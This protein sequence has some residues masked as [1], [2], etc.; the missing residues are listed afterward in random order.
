MDAQIHGQTI[1][2]TGAAGFVGSHLVDTLVDTNEVIALDHFNTNSAEVIAD[3]ATVVKG[4]IRDRKLIDRV[5]NGTDIIFHQ[6]AMRG[7]SE[8]IKEPLKTHDVNVDATLHLLESA[9]KHDARIILASS[10]AIYGNP[11]KYPITESSPTKPISPYGTQKLTIDNYAC[12]FN[13]L[14]GLE[15]VVL[16]YFNV[17]GR[18]KASGSYRSAIGAFIQQAE[19]GGPI[20]VEGDGTQT[21]DF[22][23]V[24]DVVRA[25]LLA[26]TT[27]YTGE[28]YN[29]ATGSE[30]SINEL[31][32]LV[33]DVIDP[34]R[35]IEHVDERSGEIHRSVADISKA[36]WLLEYEPSRN[37]KECLKQYQCRTA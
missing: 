2:V 22:V 24:S 17:F 8:S 25:N 23:H 35:M 9:R 18:L 26:A 28:A 7:V 5:T 36:N 11:S 10:A 19:D 4:D 34:S 6:A 20:T 1:L 12:N 14:Y 21:R 27:D 33:R 13:D 31:A 32:E 37:L 3:G 30:T 15:T 16:R 29:I